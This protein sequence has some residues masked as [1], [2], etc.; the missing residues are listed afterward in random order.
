MTIT[1]RERWQI[2]KR[3]NYEIS[4]ESHEEYFGGKISSIT[5]LGKEIL[6]YAKLIKINM[7]STSNRKIKLTTRISVSCL[8][9][10]V[11]YIRKSEWP[12]RKSLI[13]EV[14]LLVL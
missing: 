5:G 10:T 8:A 9:R 6:F 13:L 7:K 4:R 1:S 11:K 3:N 14:G 12:K 2:E